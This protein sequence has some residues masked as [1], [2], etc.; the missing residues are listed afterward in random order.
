MSNGGRELPSGARRDVPEP[1]AITLEPHREMIVVGARGEIDALTAGDLR[2]QLLELVDSGFDCVVLDLRA[3]DFI[4]STGLRAI[5]EVDSA[6][7]RSGVRFAL[8]QGASQVRRLFEVTGV[9][10]ELSFVAATEIDGRAG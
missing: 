1:F 9:A 10:G 3:V 2:K 4:D 7:R 8:I 6:S 5:L